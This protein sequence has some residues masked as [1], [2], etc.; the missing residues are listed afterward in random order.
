MMCHNRTHLHKEVVML[1]MK[2]AISTT[3]KKSGRYGRYVA[4]EKAARQAKA[5]YRD[6]L[7][8][9]SIIPVSTRRHFDVETTL[10]GRQQVVSTLK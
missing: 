3:T 8:V 5:R 7:L 1:S 4:T 6:I 2:Y 9:Y 10:S